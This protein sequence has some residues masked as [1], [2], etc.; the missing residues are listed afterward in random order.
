MAEKRRRRNSS[1]KFHGKGRENEGNVRKYKK[2]NGVFKDGSCDS[3]CHTL[4]EISVLVA[5]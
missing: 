3:Y 2:K 4:Q 1:R 5:P